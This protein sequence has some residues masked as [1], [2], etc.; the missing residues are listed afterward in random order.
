MNP[1]ISMEYF[2]LLAIAALTAAGW[3]SW[4]S[5]RRIPGR[6]R[7]AVTAC[8]ILAVGGVLLLLLNLGR[9]QERIQTLDASWAI[10]LDES[11]SM[12]FSDVDQGSRFQAARKIVEAAL[13]QS[14]DP[15]KIKL[16]G[17]S[18]SVTERDADT[19]A[20][21]TPD[22]GDTRIVESGLNLLLREKTRGSK[23]LGIL[24]L[25]DGRQ[26]SAGSPE[27]LALRAA[28]Q[29]VPIF[30]VVLGGQV[31]SRDLALEFS[32]R[33][34]VCFAG[35]PF[36]FRGEAVNHR[37]GPVSAEIFL[38]D[39]AGKT[40]DQ[41]RLLVRENERLPFQFDL[42]L[43]KPGYYE[44]IL[45]TPLRQGES[46]RANNSVGLGVFVM[47]ERL[48][49]LLLEGEPYWDTKFLSHLLRAQSNISMTAVFR[50]AEDKFFKV[51]TGADMTSSD[52][53]IFPG[54]AEE[55]AKYDLV[56]LGRGTE[57]FID[58]DRAQLLK[59]FVKNRGGCLFF[60][61]GKSYEGSD[62][63]LNALEPVTWG[64]PVQ[65]DFTLRPL[66]EGEQVG[67]FGGLLPNRDDPLWRNLPILTRAYTCDRLKS[68]TSPLA[69]GVPNQTAETP[70]PLLVSKR[71]GSGLVL[72]INADG[73]WR[74]GFDPDIAEDNPLYQNLW[75]QLFQWAVSFAEFNPGSDYMIHTDRGTARVDE[76]LRVRVRARAHVQAEDPVVQVYRGRQPVDNLVLAAETQ[77]GAGWSGL[78]ALSSPGIYRLA[79]QTTD[80]KDL[81]A[82]TSIQILPPPE[83]ADQLSADAGFLKELA[84]KSGG[85]VVAR[86]ELPDLVQQLEAPNT[87][88][89][90][91]DVHWETLWD[92]AWVLVA[93]L[94]FFALEWTFRRRQGLH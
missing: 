17:F 51:A 79:A 76:P 7:V 89:R 57:Y 32:R 66:L 50:V 12:R 5:T 1:L 49:V 44:Y 60:A 42:T 8:R 70:F 29:N 47:S 74:W 45:E 52:T 35:Q 43:E 90:K 22:G 46:D 59:D 38:R 18:G 39:G 31:P 9:Q 56:V 80:G 82:Q 25:S 14:K 10:M 81:G 67:L 11:A 28:A 24:L 83:E 30:P 37:M 93:I 36:T 20:E 72:L 55:L 54:S 91:G 77:A 86:E 88:V 4:H 85:R 63:F 19:L 62:S 13:R 27:P 26:P 75:I 40:L 6:W 92:R 2:V 23:L 69:H 71:Y 48:N 58:A 78:L 84:E 15:K 16:Y 21:Q 34:F 65:S 3:V 61:R 87:F 94:L 33:R 64:P 41:T 73:L 53:Y 68:F